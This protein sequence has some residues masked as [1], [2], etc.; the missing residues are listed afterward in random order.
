MSEVHE[1]FTEGL[2]KERWQPGIQPEFHRGE[3]KQSHRAQEQSEVDKVKQIVIELTNTPV[4]VLEMPAEKPNPT[5]PNTKLS[6]W[7]YIE[8]IL[9]MIADGAKAIFPKRKEKN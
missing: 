7:D 6:F 5:H 2:F 8:I 4:F 1:R 3:N 9:E